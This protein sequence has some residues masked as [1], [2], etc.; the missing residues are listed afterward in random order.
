MKKLRNTIIYFT[1][2][3]LIG[4]ALLLFQFIT[5]DF[6]N[7]FIT[8]FA[9]TILI[10]SVIQII[11]H[12]RIAR[13][14]KLLKKYEI[15]NTEERNIMIAQKAGYYAFLTTIYAEMLIGVVLMF[16]D[17]AEMGEIIMS[18]AA[19]QTFV[20]AIFLIYLQKKH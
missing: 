20:Y 3:G 9:I 8:S 10:I 19:L 11:R 16:I 2:F 17:R 14:E 12:A 5:H 6:E 15:R 7:N 18:V 1:G 4:F 13:D